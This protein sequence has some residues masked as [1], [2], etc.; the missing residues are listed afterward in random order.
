MNLFL[1]GILIYMY[2]FKCWEKTKPEQKPKPKQNWG[3]WKAAVDLW[4]LNF[5]HGV[6]LFCLQ[7]ELN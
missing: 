3:L 6:D 1:D 4:D 7:R 2:H 5:V